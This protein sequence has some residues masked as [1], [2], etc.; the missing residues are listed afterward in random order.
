M[1]IS[2]PLTEDLV[3]NLGGHYVRYSVYLEGFILFKV[4]YKA[5]HYWDA[6]MRHVFGKRLPTFPPKYYL[7]M[8]KSMLVERR[9]MLEKYLQEVVSDPV[10]SS[11]EIFITCFKKLQLETFKMPSVKAILKIYLPDGRQVDVDS[12]T[13]DTAE[14]VLQAALYKLN[15]SRELTEYFSLFITHTDT[16]GVFSVV[17]WVAPFEIPFLTIWNINNDSYQ[18]DIRKCYMTP[19]TDAMLM[20]CTA[21]IDLLYAQAVQELKMNWSKPTK[22]Q[23]TALM[24]L[25]KM[26]NKVKVLELMQE[27]EHYSYQK[28][29]PGVT[30]YLDDNT[31][32]TVSVGNNEL[33]CSFKTSDNKTEI[34]RLH[35]GE[36]ACWHVM[37][38]HPEKTIDQQE[39]KLRYVDGDVLKW[40]TIWTN[41]LFLLST[42]LKKMQREQPVTK[43]NLEIQEN[44]SSNNIYTRKQTKIDVPCKKESF[45]NIKCD[46]SNLSDCDL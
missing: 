33:F 42:W 12:K 3:D 40:I 13:S 18:I 26:D 46:L 15:V 27:V 21:T 43:E 25:I 2:I 32:V 4:R 6:Q 34:V 37:F 24:E 9:I 17:K 14:R 30:D 38:Y 16:N 5:L 36:V 1:H 41:Q 45:P 29:D 19:S 20:G 7:V 44:R 10:I 39:F 28:L 31:K 35:I 11:S 8:T 22:Q 23:M